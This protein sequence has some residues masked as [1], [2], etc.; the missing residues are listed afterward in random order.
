[1]LQ[2]RYKKISIEREHKQSNQVLAKLQLIQSILHFFKQQF[3]AWG[4]FHPDCRW[5]DNDEIRFRKLFPQKEGFKEL[6]IVVWHN[7]EA[8]TYYQNKIFTLM[9]GNAPD[10][11][12]EIEAQLR[13]WNAWD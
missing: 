13:E 5:S 10:Y 2:K 7:P 9:N 8:V 4:Y 1:M 3:S 6:D 12:F 11:A